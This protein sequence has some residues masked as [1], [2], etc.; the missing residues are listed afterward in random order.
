[1]RHLIAIT[2]ASLA[3][4]ACSSAPTGTEPVASTTAAQEFCPIGTKPVCTSP[5]DCK[6]VDAPPTP[7]PPECSFVIPT[8]SSPVGPQ[9]SFWIEAWATTQ[10][11]GQ[12][13]DVPTATGTWSNVDPAYYV[14]ASGCFNG[15]PCVS[16]DPQ[17][18]PPSCSAVYGST[19]CC[20]YV[21]WPAGFVLETVSGCYAAVE[22]ACESNPN[23]ANALCTS[24]GQA[25]TALEN[26]TCTPDYGDKYPC[27]QPGGSSCA[28]SCSGI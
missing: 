9:Y 12:C 14:A 22:S 20:T 11:D 6:C 13:P 18:P 23:D 16:G 1:M 19:P 27:G 5:N 24:S 25:F 21:W 15:V 17:L 7:P 28:G 26:V 8:P 2:V 3:A 10:T 4:T